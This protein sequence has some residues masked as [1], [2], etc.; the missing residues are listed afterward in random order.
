MLTVKHSAITAT[1]TLNG[2][3]ITLTENHRH[4]QIFR[5]VK[6]FRKIEQLTQKIVA[7]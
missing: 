5:F 1:N 2:T 7:R 6:K 4:G 3:E